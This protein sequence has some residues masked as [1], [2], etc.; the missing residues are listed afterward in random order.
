MF[1]VILFS[2]VRWSWKW[3][4]FPPF[5]MSEE[6]AL[7][8]RIL[9]AAEAVL[10]RHG[11]EKA[12]VVDIARSLGMSHGNIYRHYPSKK[13]ILDAVAARWMQ[14]VMV[15]LTAIADDRKKSAPERLALWFDTLREA[16][17]RKVLDDPELF[18]VYHGIAETTST[19][20]WKA[21]PT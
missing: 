3:T 9:D 8:Q 19:R 17:R 14:K 10:R 18:R 16:K 7:P 2:G 21:R 12:N 4:T 13:A 15:P 5:T 20:R 6:A 11:V 1:F